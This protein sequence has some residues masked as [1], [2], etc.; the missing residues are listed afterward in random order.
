[1]L[2][3]VRSWFS[4]RITN[5]SIKNL[6]ILMLIGFW[7][8]T[9]VGAL[10]LYFPAQHEPKELF[11]T[12]GLMTIDYAPLWITLAVVQF[13]PF[14]VTATSRKFRRFRKYALAI[15]GT[16]FLMAAIPQLDPTYY[17][18]FYT[19]CARLSEPEVI[20]V[21]HAW[22]AKKGHSVVSLL[23]AF[24]RLGDTIE[25]V[26]RSELVQ[27]VEW[28]LGDSY[29]FSARY[30]TPRDALFAV[31]IGPECAIEVSLTSLAP[32]LGR[33]IYEKQ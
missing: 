25:D 18:S 33:L 4:T 24:S 7:S 11:F 1:M 32:P 29:S 6:L 8:G 9:F 3:Q 5:E 13:G 31:N 10:L 27:L 23:G 14:I 17:S 12:G 22:I 15:L 21:A 20:E 26:Q 28:R 16:P 2:G 19:R 30:R